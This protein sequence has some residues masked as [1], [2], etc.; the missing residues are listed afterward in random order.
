[1]NDS[2][3]SSSQCSSALATIGA[4]RI[5]RVERRRAW[6][7]RPIRNSRRSA[8]RSRARR[9]RRPGTSPCPARAAGARGDRDGRGCSA[10]CRRAE[11]PGW[12]AGSSLADRPPDWPSF[13][14]GFRPGPRRPCVLSTATRTT[15]APAAAR[16]F[17]WATVAATFCVWVAVMLCT[18]IGWPAPIE[19]DPMRTDRLGLRRSSTAAKSSALGGKRR[20]TPL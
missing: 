13:G 16:S 8:W 1:M 9:P 11:R 15:S 14:G 19:I 18:A 12:P 17:T 10:A 5:G 3:S 4:E 6:P 2:R 7:D 20:P